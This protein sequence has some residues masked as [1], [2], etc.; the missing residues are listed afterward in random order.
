MRDRFGEEAQRSRAGEKPL[1]AV[2]HEE[3]R[4][5][6]GELVVDDAGRHELGRI[7]GGAFVVESGPDLRDHIGATETEHHRSDAVLRSDAG[8][9]GAGAG[10]EQRRMGRLHRSRHDRVGGATRRRLDREQVGV[11]FDLVVAPAP[12]E[13]AQRFA[14]LGL[15]RAAVDAAQAELLLGAAARAPRLSRP[16]LMMSSIAARS[17]TRTGWLYPNGMHT[18][19]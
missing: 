10:E 11:P 1:L 3:R 18:A 13:E 19:A 2:V 17:A 14:H 9:F 12:P 5:Q 8:R 15:G 6:R 16:P 7:V 4:A